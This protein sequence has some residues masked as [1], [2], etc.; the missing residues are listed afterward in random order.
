MSELF[1]LCWPESFAKLVFFCIE[2]AK[3][4]KRMSDEMS[5]SSYHSFGSLEHDFSLSSSISVAR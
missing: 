3:R 2:R 1:F 4:R 5:I